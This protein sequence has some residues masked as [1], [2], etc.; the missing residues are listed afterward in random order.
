MTQIL[1]VPMPAD[2]GIDIINWMLASNSMIIIKIDDNLMK[3]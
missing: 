2:N 1:N 3:Q